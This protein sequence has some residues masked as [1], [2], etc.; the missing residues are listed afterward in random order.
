MKNRLHIVL[1]VLSALAICSA[2]DSKSSADKPATDPALEKVL[3]QMDESSA[4]FKTAQVDFVWD[5]YQKVVDE[6]DIQK[7]TGWFKRD[8]K[9][10]K[11]AAEIKTP[12]KKQ[13]VYADGKI[14]FYQPRIDQ[15]TEYEAASHKTEVESFLVLGFGGRGHDMAKAFHLKLLGH[16][17]INGVDCAKLELVPRSDKVLNMFARI[18]LWIDTKND[19]SLKQEAFEPSGDNR[20]AI[21]TNL[22]MNNPIKNDVFNLKTTNKTKT[23]K[24]Q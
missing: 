17:T 23:V 18:L 8:N 16:E 14:R 22:Q 9:E 3:I 24:P 2:Q 10:T 4:N 7:G 12:E 15:V 19:V 21:Y 11:M 13:I 1:M 5:Q 20:I 6:H